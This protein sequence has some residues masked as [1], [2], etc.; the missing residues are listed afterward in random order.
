M[1]TGILF[2]LWPALRATRPDLISAMRDEGTG[3]GAGWRRSRLR[4]WLVGGQVAVSMLLLIT[5]GLLA[6]G[7]VRSRVA[8]PGFDMRGLYL[9]TGDFGHDRAE[10]LARQRRV[11]DRLRIAPDLSGVAVGGVPMVGTWTPPMGGDQIRGRRLASYAG[12]G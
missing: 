3:F 6:R 4:S 9:L 2:G 5:A 11:I 1:A 10:A 7:L 8:D 12:G